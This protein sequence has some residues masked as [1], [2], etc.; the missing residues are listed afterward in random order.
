MKSIL[1][2]L[3]VAA[4]AAGCAT[5]ADPE[6]MIAEG[7]RALESASACATPDECAAAFKAAHITNG[8]DE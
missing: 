3:V 4:I 6:A 5:V 2:A 8:A 7:A 1:F